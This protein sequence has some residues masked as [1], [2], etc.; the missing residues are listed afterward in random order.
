MPLTSDKIRA[1]RVQLGW[2][3]GRLARAA[4]LR[5]DVIDRA[6]RGAEADLLDLGQE[7]AIRRAF[8]RAGVEFTSNSPSVRPQGGGA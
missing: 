1:A 2:T 4:F 3:T 7:L 5:L 8:E 6:E